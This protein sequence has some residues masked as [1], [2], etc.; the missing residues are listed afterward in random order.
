[1]KTV[2]L[3]LILLVFSMQIFA[4]KSPDTIKKIVLSEKSY[5]ISNQIK[6]LNHQEYIFYPNDQV[7]VLSW[8]DMRG[9]SAGN[10][11]LNRGSWKYISDSEI[12]VQIEFPGSDYGQRFIYQNSYFKVTDIGISLSLI[13]VLDGAGKTLDEYPQNNSL[14]SLGELY[15][16]QRFKVRYPKTN[17]YDLD[18][19][20]SNDMQKYPFRMI[21]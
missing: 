13:R 20:V 19:V 6:E 7:A 4:E 15:G 5:R 2:L 8:F 1:M 10:P 14:Y 17:S 12:V 18:F 9:N 21:E 16:P 3:A 11:V